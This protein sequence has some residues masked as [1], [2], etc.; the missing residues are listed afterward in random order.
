M[1]DLKES[2][3]NETVVNGDCKSFVPAHT[4]HTDAAADFT[5]FE[6]LATNPPSGTADETFAH[7]ELT[8][9]RTHLTSS[10][11]HLKMPSDPVKMHSD[12]SVAN[13]ALKGE[14]RRSALVSAAHNDSRINEYNRVLQK[15]GLHE[16]T[17]NVH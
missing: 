17:S 10:V 6:S 9:D 8:K 14:P 5:E 7:T 15:R 16:D 2:N 1:S 3:D 4:E 12:T 11:K 13:K